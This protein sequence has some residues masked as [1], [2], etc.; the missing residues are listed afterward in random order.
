MLGL[1]AVAGGARE[2]VYALPFER[3][4]HVGKSGSSH[5]LRGPMPLVRR[6]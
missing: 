1:T 3:N 6:K 2:G 5:V 4:A